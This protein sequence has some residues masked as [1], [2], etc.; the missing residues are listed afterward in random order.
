MAKVSTEVGDRHGRGTATDLLVTSPGI[1]MEPDR[2]LHE[3]IA[4]AQSYRAQAK[5]A[6]TLR[7][8][9]SDWNQFE[10]WCDERSLDPMPARPEAVATYLAS[11]ALSG[12]ADTTISRHLAAIGWKHR[13][14]G[15]VPPSARDARRVIADTLAGIRREARTRPSARK[16][17]ITARELAAMIAAAEGEG[18]RSVR[19]RAIMALGLA[20]ALR[21]SELVALERRDVEM[22]DKGL[23]LTLRH[24]KTDQEGAGQVIAVPTGKALKPVERLKAWLALRGA[25][26]GPLF[27]QIDPQGR[28]TDQ[29]MSDRSI[30][31]LIQKYAGRIGLDPEMFAGHSLRAGFLTE[32][33]RA[34][35]TISKMQEVSR[36]KK[37]EVLL[38]YVRSAELFD[39]HAGMAFL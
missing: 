37:V 17:A 34:G 25:D 9:T 4:A 12:K 29:P 1:I 16:A 26:A 35:A 33:S 13:Q 5:A 19:D 30:A 31:R 24:S 21:R 6:N 38:G 3:E 36:H 32:A 28:L 7:A 20:A 14:D 11:L 18:T 2:R 22:V 15:Q 8:Y 10:A 23:K 27:Y 39:D